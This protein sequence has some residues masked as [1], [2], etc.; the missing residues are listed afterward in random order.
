MDNMKAVRVLHVLNSMNN[1]GG[2]EVMIM[3]HYRY[4]DRTKL[5]FDFLI[6][7][8]NAG[9][10]DAEIYRLGGRIF[11]IQYSGKWRLIGYIRMLSKI[12][13]VYGPFA[14]IHSHIGTHSGIVAYVAKKCGVGRR[15]IHSHSTSW[16]GNPN[17]FICRAKLKIFRFLVKRYA[18]MLC[19]C[20]KSAGIF[21]FG[22]DLFHLGR[23]KIVNN[24]IDLECFKANPDI[25]VKEKLKKS[26]G[27]VGAQIIIG[28]VGRIAEVKNHVFML[29]LARCLKRNSVNFKLLF[30]G[31]GPLKNNIM[32]LASD[33]AI[34]DCVC[35]LGERDD[36]SELIHVLDV[37]LLPSVYE[38]LPL[39]LI[40]AQA[41]GVPCVVANSI[42]Q[43]VDMG[44]G[45]LQYVSL[46]ASMDA[47]KD[48]IFKALI[49]L[50]PNWD[51]VYNAISVRGYD[52]RLNAKV[53]M[54]LYGLPC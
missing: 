21:L 24:A 42:T 19:A 4:I 3:N 49:T 7:E 50:K 53:L 30:V 22:E 12:I 32:C 44:L 6:N 2:V 43:E 38:G 9:I 54:G 26:L 11:R 17:V 45:L 20:G 36:V 15:I 40:E 39:V 48:A 14:A 27:I 13:K 29:H 37:F 47:W 8:K 28:H 18:S 34:S 10:W 1:R 41:A 46:N 16:G 23:V 33:L 35:F 51:D 25:D 52:S 31:D 5:Q